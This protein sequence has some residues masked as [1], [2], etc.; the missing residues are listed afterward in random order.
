VRIQ[1]Q[2]ILAI[3]NLVLDSS[4]LRSQMQLD[5]AQLGTARLQ[6][7]ATRADNF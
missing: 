6:K 7:D 1:R 3:A 5:R 2:R 4:R